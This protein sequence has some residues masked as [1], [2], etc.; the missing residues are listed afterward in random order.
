M[1][2]CFTNRL[3]AIILATALG[4]GSLCAQV[5]F[6]APG[7]FYD[8]TFLLTLASPLGS[9]HYTLDGTVPTAASPLYSAPLMLSPELYSCRNLFS[10]QDAPDEW[11]NPPRDVERVIVVRAAA[12]DGA[13]SRL[14]LEIVNTYFISELT[15]YVPQLPM[16]SIVIDPSELFDTLKGVFSPHGWDADDD[17]R[18]GN[19]NQH[20]RE[21]E[22]VAHIEF[23]E[24]TSGGFSGNIGLRVHGGKTRRYMQKPLKLYARSEYGMKYINH[25]V[26][27]TEPYTSYKRLVLKPFCASWEANGIADHLAHNIAAPLR[28][29]SMASRPVS[30]YINGEYWGIYFLQESPDERLIEMMD[31]V[32]A[33]DVD[34]IGSWNGLVENG[35][36]EA[37]GQL[38]EFL[39]NAD[40]TDSMQFSQACSLIDI[41]NFIDYQ[42]FEA[43]IANRDWPANNMRCYRHGQSPWRWLFYDGDAAFSNPKL[44][45][46]DRLTY[47]GG[48]GWPSSAVA[49]LCLRRLLQSP[50]FLQRFANRMDELN[51]TVFDYSRTAPLLACAIE[52]IDDEINRQS[53][54][55]GT[56]VSTIQWKRATRSIDSFLRRRSAIFEGQ[57]LDILFQTEEPEAI[58]FVYPNPASD[59]VNV[60]CASNIPR[61]VRC[62]I[63]DR[64]GRLV[65]RR[66]FAAFGQTTVRL[67]VSALPPGVYAVR[68]IPGESH[69]LILNSQSLR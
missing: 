6:S 14:G 32:D 3:A 38:M 23:C 40:L 5:T 41:D 12:F 54:R 64:L 7:G 18:T 65:T 59:A 44:D 46:T 50:A 49:T 67:D 16:L 17:F 52:E 37:F 62:E 2:V 25:K 63:Y 36:G 34:L 28:M 39:D 22:R 43:F 4:T 68:F 9:V 29:V 31:N 26:F 48:E 47:T 69:K 8:H 21:W 35:S 56:P 11:W 30:V 1:T 55:F 13:G 24:P 60:R 57:M 61:L 10:M 19:F 53:K 33:D 42:L 27:K 15:G 58:F 45:M 51:A 20:G 66:T